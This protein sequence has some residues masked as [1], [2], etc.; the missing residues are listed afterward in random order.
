MCS[1]ETSK[2]KVKSVFLVA[3]S[4]DLA[5]RAALAL[6]AKRGNVAQVAE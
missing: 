1:N 3:P 6:K 4:S 2:A 5:S